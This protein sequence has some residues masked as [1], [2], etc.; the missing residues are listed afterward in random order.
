MAIPNSV[1]RPGSHGELWR[2]LLDNRSAFLFVGLFSAV[3]NLLLLT[4]AIY[5]LQVYDRVLQSRNTDTLLMLTLVVMLMFVMIGALEAVRSSILVRLSA[6]LDETFRDRVFGAAF[7]QSLR[8]GGANPALAF[9]DMTAIRQFVTG[10]GIFAFFDAPWIPVYVLV[11]FLLH[12]WIGGFTLLFVI[13]LFALTLITG[14]LTSP[15][16]ES[17]NMHASNALRLIGNHLRNAEVIEAMGMLAGIRRK[18][19]ESH[20]RMLKSQEVASER[21]GAAAALSRFLRIASQSLVLGLG[22]LLVIQGEITPG[23]MIASSILMGRALAPVDQLISVWKQFGAARLSY[24]RLQGLLATYPAGEKKMP[25]PPPHGAVRV[26]SLVA[27]APGGS[28][29]ILRG[30]GFQLSPGEALAVVGPSGSGKSTLARL[31]VGVWQPR[32][33]AVRLDG[34][35]VASWDKSELGP[36]IGYLPQDIELF[37]GTVAENIA[38]FGELDGDKVIAAAKLAGVHEMILRLP[39]GYDTEVGAGG[40][41]LSG[42]QRQRIGLARA[43]YREPALTVLDEPNSNLDEAGEA[44]LV[45]AIQAM[46]ASGKTV[47]LITHRAAVANVADRMLVLAAGQIKHFGPREDVLAALNKGRQP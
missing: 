41:A 46:R 36:H 6:R 34:A 21:A 27:V 45:A 35:E 14:K 9:Q 44:A 29:P 11:C 43:L 22:V 12:P 30:I 28:E 15:P 37:E 18:W 20:E 23:V 38:R 3:V 32:A 16:L 5:M 2:A 26:E 7:E 13:V 19:A 10:N 1:A 25:L 39:L 40:G 8:Q 33:G 42:G 24:Q 31:L 47:V 4:P 17:A